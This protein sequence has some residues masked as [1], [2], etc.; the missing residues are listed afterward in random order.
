MLQYLNYDSLNIDE[1]LTKIESCESAEIVLEPNNKNFLFILG[2]LFV[3]GVE[4]KILNEKDLIDS[5]VMTWP[6]I[7]SKARTL[8]K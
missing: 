6:Y 4:I 8:S 2:M 5:I 1:E 3:N 7:K